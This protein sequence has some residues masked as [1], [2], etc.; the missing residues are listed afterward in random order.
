MLVSILLFSILV[1]SNIQEFDCEKYI[2]V[3]EYIVGYDDLETRGNRISF[4]Y[5]NNMAELS[6]SGVSG[7]SEIDLNN[8]L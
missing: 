7:I 5:I 2:T 8:L 4:D 6:T 1:S 3:C